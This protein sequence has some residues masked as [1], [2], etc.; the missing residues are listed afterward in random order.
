[1][2]LYFHILASMCSHLSFYLRH[3]DWCELEYWGHFD[4]YFFDDWGFWIFQ[5]HLSHSK[6]FCCEFC[7]ATY[8][9][10][11]GL[12]WVFGSWLLEFLIYFGYWSSDGGLVKCFLQSVG[13]WFIV[14][15]VPFAL[16]K[17]FSF[18]RFLFVNWSLSLRNWCSVHEISPVPMSFNLF[19]TFFF[20]RFSVFDFM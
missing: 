13:F 4:F 5:V 20:I 9:I 6:F 18:M 17:L 8:P 10:F 19:S 2:F 1:M 15:T 7:L 14:V 12:I 3:T 16:Q 11:N